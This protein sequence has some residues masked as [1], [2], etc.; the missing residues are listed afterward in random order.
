[1]II[2]NRKPTERRD[3]IAYQSECAQHPLFVVHDLIAPEELPPC[4]YTT[5]TGAIDESKVMAD[6]YDAVVQFVPLELR[7]IYECIVYLDEKMLQLKI[8]IWQD[9]DYSHL[10]KLIQSA[11][12]ILNTLSD[13]NQENTNHGPTA[14][15]TIDSKIEESQPEY[16]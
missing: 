4:Q 16:C 3:W 10:I 8:R 7:S 6:G 2:L 9:R 14:N 15:K 1:M 5:E 12:K 13:C 11:I